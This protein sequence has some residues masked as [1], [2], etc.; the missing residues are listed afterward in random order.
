MTPPPLPSRMMRLPR[1]A[2]GLPIPYFV[3]T[4]NGKPDFR[5]AD[6]DKMPKAIKHRICW[7]CGQPMGRFM[8]FVVGPMCVVNRIS[9][10]PPNHL[11]CAEYAVQACP[12]L[13]RPH[14][15]RR[16]GGMPDDRYMAGEAIL[17]NP[18]VTVIYT[19]RRFTTFRAGAGILFDMGEAS[20]VSW[21]SHGRRATREEAVQSIA[22]GMPILLEKAQSEGPM[23]I[24]ELKAMALQAA[25]LLP[26]DAAP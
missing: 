23:A 26:A 6:A 11:D 20:S 16:E 1:T 3:A 22:S 19:V 13:T 2:A 17:R 25:K 12:F 21:W 4:V 10:E 7:L 9:S 5:V 14:A 24:A 8:C 15:A 18:G